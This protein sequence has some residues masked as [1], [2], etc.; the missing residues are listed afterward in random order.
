MLDLPLRK[1]VLEVPIP[2][3]EVIFLMN[4]LT[5]AQLLAIIGRDKLTAAAQRAAK[6]M[7]GGEGEGEGDDEMIEEITLS[8][9]YDRLVAAFPDH[10][11]GAVN[12]SFDGEAFDPKNEDHIRS[13]PFAWKMTAVSQLIAYATVLPKK[14]LGN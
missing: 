9:D 5:D 8:V 4:S 13:I 2:D 12:L 11:E 7:Q 3:T 10:V 14:V 1:A 6:R